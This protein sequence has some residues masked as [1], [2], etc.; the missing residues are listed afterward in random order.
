MVAAQ[1]DNLQMLGSV[2]Q[3]SA[4]PPCVL[5]TVADKLNL[6]MHVH[7]MDAYW[8]ELTRLTATLDIVTNGIL[9]MIMQTECGSIDNTG[10]TG[11]AGQLLQ[12][13]ADPSRA[14]GNSLAWVNCLLQCTGDKL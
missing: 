10:Q 13:R 5:H 2:D 1:S 14:V 6:V 9:T 3:G 11:V 12:L 4:A 7:A 8:V